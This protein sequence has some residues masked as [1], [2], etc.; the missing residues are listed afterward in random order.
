M[1]NE[2]QFGKQI[3]ILRA[4]AGQTQ[5]QL[6]KASGVATSIVND[7]EN[8]IRSAGSKTVNKIALGLGLSD[9]ERYLLI[10]AGLKFSKRDFLIPDFADYSPELLNFL[11]YVLNKAGIK[12][13]H[14]KKIELPDQQRKNLT[15]TLKTKKKIQLDIRISASKE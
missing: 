3:K 6:A 7:V 4:K 8:G 12:S 11:P 14:I 5:P 15:I 2:K 13:K 1:S 10:L 9:Q